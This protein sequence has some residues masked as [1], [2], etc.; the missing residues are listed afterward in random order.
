MIPKN[1]KVL[2]HSGK[3]YVKI[4]G[5]KRQASW[6]QTKCNEVVHLHGKQLLTNFHKRN[7]NE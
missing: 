6:K 5:E 1:N 3:N 4:L 2:S 7:K